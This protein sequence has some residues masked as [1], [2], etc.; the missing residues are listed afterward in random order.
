[1]QMRKPTTCAPFVPAVA[2]TNRSCK[3]ANKP[4]LQMR[5]CVCVFGL[6]ADLKSL[7]SGGGTHLVQHPETL[8]KRH[9]PHTDAS[10][11]SQPP[12]PKTRKGGWTNAKQRCGCGA[13]HRPSSLPSG[14]R[15]GSASGAAREG[16]V[17]TTSVGSTGEV[18]ATVVGEE[19]SSVEEE[20]GDRRG[21]GG[22]ADSQLRGTSTGRASGE[23][24][25]RWPSAATSGKAGGSAAGA[26]S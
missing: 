15:N 25:G 16:A 5:K 2:Q 21:G 11:V 3:C 20:V 19:R 6:F 9:H 1:M 18:V 10:A 26:I 12:P 8:G 24:L 7:H 17:E 4:F 23:E 22:G 13:A 14:R